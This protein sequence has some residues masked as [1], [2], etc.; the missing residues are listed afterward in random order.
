MPKIKNL[1]SKFKVPI[2]EKELELLLGQEVLGAM[3]GGL[4]LFSNKFRRGYGDAVFGSDEN[5]IWLGQ[6]EFED[7][8]FRVD[9]AG[10]L[11]AKSATFKDGED[12]TI[13]DSGGLVSTASF[14]IKELSGNP[15]ATFSNTSYANVSGTSTLSFTLT[16]SIKAVVFLT[17]NASS[18][19]INDTLD[20]N[21]R[22]SYQANDN[23]DGEL[24]SLLYDSFITDADNNRENIISKPYTSFNALTLVKGDHEV[25]IRSKIGS[26]VNFESVRTTFNI[27][28]VILGT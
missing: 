10:A 9:M 25:N 24:T 11:V 7:A 27:S 17:T 14:T 26:N 21:G 20:C 28:I 19:Q 13:I 8:P 2:A 4:S 15:N 18:Q 5:G 1:S 6:A 16:R 23:L 12:T 22:T 3:S